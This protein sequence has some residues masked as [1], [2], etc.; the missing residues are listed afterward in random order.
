MAIKIKNGEITDTTHD[1]DR[2]TSAL[3]I[4]WFLDEEHNKDIYDD[5]IKTLE[6]NNNVFFCKVFSFA[7]DAAVL[8]GYVL[9][10]G[11]FVRT[12]LSKLSEQILREQY[13][14]IL[15]IL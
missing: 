10:D 9:E 2:D 1:L 12:F 13:E 14:R 7:N 15:Q 11:I 5:T 4:G 3:I 6:F 8:A